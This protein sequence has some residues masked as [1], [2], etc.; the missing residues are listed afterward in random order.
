MLPPVVLVVDPLSQ[1]AERIASA[2]AG[3][4]LAV[5]AVRD[6]T[7]AEVSLGRERVVAVISSVTLPRGNGY[8]LAKLVRL[9]APEV[10]FFLLAGGFDVYSPERAMEAGV[11]ARIARPFTADGIRR[12]LEL[13]LGPLTGEEPLTATVSVDDAAEALAEVEPEPVSVEAVP[14]PLAPPITPSEPPVGDERLSSFLPRDWSTFPPVRVDPEVVGPAMERAILAV[15]PQVVEVVLNKAIATSPA[16][17]ELLEQAVM[18]AVREELPAMA[19]RVIRER[20]AE[21]E[22]RGE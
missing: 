21:I 6:A 19:R 7:E 14:L 8:D 9:R 10:A 18:E 13:A 2:L 22:K 15:L 3:T 1:T 17:R 20:M 5:H 16:F 4:R 11:T 12:P